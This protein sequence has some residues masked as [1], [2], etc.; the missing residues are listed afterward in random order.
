M[1][2]SIELRLFLR[3]NPSFTIVFIYSEFKMSFGMLELSSSFAMWCVYV[4]GFSGL[5]FF[6]FK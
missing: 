1:C 6:F 4:Y 3:Q 2:P 5:L